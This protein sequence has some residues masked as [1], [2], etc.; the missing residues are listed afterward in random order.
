MSEHLVESAL[1]AAAGCLLGALLA[2]LLGRVLL[3][4]L[5]QQGASGVSL[6]PSLDMRALAFALTAAAV[7]TL[8]CGV[9]P[10][11]YAASVGPLEALKR[12]SISIAGGLGVRKALVVGQFALALVS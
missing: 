6:S 9:A 5:P 1:L 7:T 3:S 4:F 2:P 12:Q 8:A 11:L 10:A